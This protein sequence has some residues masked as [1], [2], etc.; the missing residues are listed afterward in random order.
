M[1]MPPRE[2]R[3]HAVGLQK[4]PGNRLRIQQLTLIIRTTLHPP[5]IPTA[6]ANPPPPPRGIKSAVS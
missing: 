5:I 4:M 2:E 3:K 1:P 6:Q